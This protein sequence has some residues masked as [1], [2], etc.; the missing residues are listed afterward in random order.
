MR[1]SQERAPSF[2]NSRNRYR[3]RPQPAS[4][5]TEIIAAKRPLVACS[6]IGTCCESACA[7]TL[8]RKYPVGV[9]WLVMFLI[10]LWA[11]FGFMTAKADSRHDVV[12]YGF[13]LLFIFL[14][15]VAAIFHTI[16]DAMEERKWRHQWERLHGKPWSE[17]EAANQERGRGG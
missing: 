10:P 12:G 3:C 9:Q 11:W 4:D 6:T 17:S 5:S 14:P 13:G 7:E 2:R 15:V 16:K 8:M 1:F